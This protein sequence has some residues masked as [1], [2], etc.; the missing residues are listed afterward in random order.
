MRRRPAHMIKP[1]TTDGDVLKTLAGKAV[2][3]SAPGGSSTAVLYDAKGD[4]LVGSADDAPARLAVG[5]NGQVLTADSASSLGVKW[6]TPAA[7]GGSA[8]TAYTPVLTATTTNPTLGTGATQTGW[9]VQNGDLI[10]GEA[11]IKFGTS[12]VNAGAGDY[13][14][15]LPVAAHASAISIGGGWIYNG[16]SGMTTVSA[17][18]LIGAP[19]QV[20]LFRTSST[21]FTVG[22]AVPSPWVATNELGLSFAYR[23]A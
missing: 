12:G 14:I 6:A 18:M 22:A 10:V 21:T 15:S 1:S 20:R 7:G 23:K 5:S 4:I 3:G 19:T 2:W 11:Y 13:R 17:V 16:T 8:A 9:Y